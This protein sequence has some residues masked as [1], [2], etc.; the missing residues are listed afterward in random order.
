MNS[1]N[2]LY[3]ELI[4]NQNRINILKKLKFT[5]IIVISQSI[6]TIAIV[7]AILVYFSQHFFESISFFS[8]FFLSF[9]VI[10]VVAI[11]FLYSRQIY[12]SK[13]VLDGISD[14]K[15][16]RL[17]ISKINEIIFLLYRSQVGEKKKIRSLKAKNDISLFLIYF[18]EKI[19]KQ[20]YSFFA[21]LINIF[22]IIPFFRSNHQT[23]YVILIISNILLIIFSL[24][25]IY[26]T[27]SWSKS[28]SKLSN[29]DEFFSNY[30]IIPKE[31][32]INLLESDFNR[33]KDEY[34]NQI[35]KCPICGENNDFYSNFC[36]NCGNP[37]KQGDY[38]N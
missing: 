7:L 1:K 2:L 20:I 12:N 14:L 24:V 4:V 38:L 17:F 27:K 18:N 11:I 28:Y 37:L 35:I 21:Y 30:Q 34:R 16:Q 32:E 15:K 13:L 19:K 26:F 23:L 3:P 6:I 5:A 10:L 33:F 9:L 22:S 8:L 36:E 31:N 29:W 25:I